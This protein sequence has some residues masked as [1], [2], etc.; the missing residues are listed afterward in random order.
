M[1]EVVVVLWPT[2]ADRLDELSRADVPHLVL[3]EPGAKLPE[4]LG[5][6]GCITLSAEEYNVA[7]A[8]VLA[9]RFNR[10]QHEDQIHLE[11][12]LLTYRDH[13]TYLSPGQERIVRA[14]LE[15]KGRSVCELD[16]IDATWPGGA[17]LKDPAQALRTA[18]QRLRKQ[19][20]L[21]GLDLHNIRPQRYVLQ[22]MR[23]NPVRDD[24][25]RRAIDGRN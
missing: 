5:L 6:Q 16:L 21:L 9:L 3:A 11:D 23:D 1:A 12:G 15:K 7:R 4:P 20:R 17:A 13:A 10:E 19:L 8:Q 14:L 22:P 25:A 18:V 24:A 2:E